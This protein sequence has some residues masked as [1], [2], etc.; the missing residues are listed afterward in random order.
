MPHQW[1]FRYH[2][3][4]TYCQMRSTRLPDKLLNALP[5]DLFLLLLHQE[6]VLRLSQMYRPASLFQHGIQSNHLCHQKLQDQ[7]LEDLF[8]SEL[9]SRQMPKQHIQLH[10]PQTEDQFCQVSD[11][12]GFEQIHNIITFIRGR[13]TCVSGSPKRA[14][15]SSTFGPSLVNIS[16]KKMIPWK[17]R[18]SERI[19]ST[20]G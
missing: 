12:C 2:V 5:L 6:L 14:L 19:A 9:D 17:V 16:P 7:K 20:V 18:P 11:Q 13:T 3:S 1:P 8:R 15:Y 4:Y 10:Y